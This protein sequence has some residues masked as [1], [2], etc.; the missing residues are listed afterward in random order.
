[1]CPNHRIYF[2]PF[3]DKSC[4]W[5]GRAV[6]IPRSEP[7]SNRNSFKNKNDIRYEVWSW[8]YNPHL[9]RNGSELY[10]RMRRY[11]E[12]WWQLRNML[13]LK[14]PAQNIGAKHTH[15]SL[16]LT[17]HTISVFFLS[18]LVFCWL[19]LSC[20]HTNTHTHKGVEW[21]QTVRFMPPFM[22]RTKVNKEVWLEKAARPVWSSS[23]LL[24]CSSELSGGSDGSVFSTLE[25]KV[26][27]ALRMTREEPFTKTSTNAS[28]AIC[29]KLHGLHL[30]QKSPILHLHQL[31]NF[32]IKR[33]H[34][35]VSVRG[36]FVKARCSTEKSK[37]S[38]KKNCDDTIMYYSNFP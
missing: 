33:L 25:R 15:I 23:H 6:I 29:L 16:Q 12:N 9:F 4:G 38:K 13:L 28:F 34:F 21:H 1:M 7:E 22:K 14:E 37:K 35:L 24:S 3:S 36:L 10:V 2:V 17:A 18:C 8:V 19:P 5:R 31:I 32:H 11:C 30:N 27:V 20:T 26:W